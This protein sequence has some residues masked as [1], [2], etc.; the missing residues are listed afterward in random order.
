MREKTF[1]KQFADKLD[2]RG[3]SECKILIKCSSVKEE[4]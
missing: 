3:M 4:F 2:Y 1:F